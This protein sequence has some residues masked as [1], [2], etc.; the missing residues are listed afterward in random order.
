MYRLQNDLRTRKSM[1]AIRKG[2]EECLAEKP[3]NKIHV[4]DI[5]DKC[6]VSRATFYRLFD[7]IYDILALECDMIREETFNAVKNR[8]FKNKSEEIL[9]CIKRWL[10]HEVL[11]KAIVDNK[12]IG[13]LYESH[14]RNADQVKRFYHVTYE[15]EQQFHCFVS[16]LVSIIYA[17]LSLYFQK[18]ENETIEKIYLNVV[19]NSEIIINNWKLGLIG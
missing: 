19:S 4:T 5:H 18:E 3:L 14:M 8:P 1:E 9:F 2:L 6:N 11:I 12:L 10:E 7:S 13:L 17:S 16:V 15:D